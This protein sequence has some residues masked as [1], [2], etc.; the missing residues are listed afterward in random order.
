MKE[1]ITFK[2]GSRREARAEIVVKTDFI[3]FGSMQ[4]CTDAGIS[5][6]D[7]WELVNSARRL[8]KQNQ[9]RAVY[10]VMVDKTDDAACHRAV[11]DVLADYEPG[12]AK[13]SR[14]VDLKTETGR[15]AMIRKMVDAMGLVGQERANKIEEMI[16]LM[17]PSKAA[18]QLYEFYDAVQKMDQN[19]KDKGND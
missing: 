12:M 7:V 18:D 13:V 15:L 2:Y 1:T 16:Q 14:K 8:A 3:K 4:E 5:E 17:T 19:I 6:E 11:L 9:A 10:E